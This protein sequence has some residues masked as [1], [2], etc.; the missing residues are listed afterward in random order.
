MERRFA[1]R[2]VRSRE[3]ADPA[4]G[5][6]DRCCRRPESNPSAGCSEGRVQASRVVPVCRSVVTH[7]TSSI[8]RS[9]EI[10]WGSCLGPH[11]PPRHRSIPRL[12]R[13][14]LPDSPSTTDATTTEP[15]ETGGSVVHNAVRHHNGGH[16]E[17]GLERFPL[18]S[19]RADTQRRAGVVSRL[20]PERS[21]FP[22]RVA[23]G[24]PAHTSPIR[25]A[26]VSRLPRVLQAPV[27]QARAR[28]AS[29]RAGGGC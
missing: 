11:A 5:T 9:G 27:P 18:G 25:H 16:T 8:V 22:A 4:Q 13:D 17:G 6:R 3:P 21:A 14:H 29:Q 28:V 12:H 20:R 24:A 1:D 23:P 15:P 26:P 7:S 2:C 19:Y 10:G